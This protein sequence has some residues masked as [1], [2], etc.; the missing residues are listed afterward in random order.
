MQAL[1]GVEIPGRDLLLIGLERSEGHIRVPVQET[2]V[3]GS[4]RWLVRLSQVQSRLDRW[5]HAQVQSKLSL[6]IRRSHVQNKF[7]LEI[8]WSEIN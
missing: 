3:P 5:S 7:S 4:N 6:K 1:I 8:R 2:S